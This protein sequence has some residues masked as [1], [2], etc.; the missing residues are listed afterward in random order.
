[1][2]KHLA[3][4]LLAAAAAPALA[5]DPLPPDPSQP[6][7]PPPDPVQPPPPDPSMAPP[8]PPATAPPPGEQPVVNTRVVGP[9]LPN[10][11]PAR[12]GATIDIRGDY[13]YTSQDDALFGELFLLAFNFY[14]SYITPQGFGGYAQSPYWYARTTGDGEDFSDKGVGNLEVGGLYLLPQ[15]PTSQILLRAGIALDTASSVGAFISP[16]SAL[17]PRLYDAYPTGFASTWGRGEGSFRHSSGN[18]HLGAS[19]GV[20]VPITSADEEED[21]ISIDIDAIGK[22]AISASMDA[23]G[24]SVGLGFVMMQAFGVDSDDERIFGL[25]ANVAFPINPTMSLY[26]SFGFPDLENNTEELS[27]FGFGAGIRIAAQ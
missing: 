16:F 23:G 6:Q 2:K 8:P 25:N 15:G 27:I 22:A 18:L 17:A 20:D 24:A 13:T 19:V 4:A 3:L 9:I 14:G 1:M 10:M 5:Q 26:G 11:L 21:G 12:V 7:P